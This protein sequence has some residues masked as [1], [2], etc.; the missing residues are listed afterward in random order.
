MLDHNSDQLCIDH[1]LPISILDGAIEL[2]VGGILLECVHYVVEVNEESLI[3]SIS[4]VRTES[5]SDDPSAQC[6]HIF[7]LIFHSHVS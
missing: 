5:S 7:T 4:F 3:I 2:T 1:K 6:T